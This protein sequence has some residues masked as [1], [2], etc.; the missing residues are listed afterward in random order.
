MKKLLLIL[1]LALSTTAFSQVP[2]Y[3]PTS[4]L[5]AWWPFNG[6]AI[7]ESVNTNDGTVNGATLTTDRF[8]NS[9][10]AYYFNVSHW[11]FGSGGDD[12][13]I[14]YN[15]TFNFSDF[16]VSS[17]VKRVSGGSTIDS[18][19]QWL[20]IIRRSQYGYSTPNGETWGLDIGNGASVNGPLL[21][22]GVVEQSPSPAPG[23]QCLPS[24]TVPLNQ[25]S[26]IT[27]TYSLKTI[28]LY[29]DGL[30]VCSTTN[31]GITINTVGNS[32]ISIGL[33]DQANGH[34]GPFDG[35]ID[36][37]GIWNRALTQI[38]ITA[39]FNSSNVGINE[40]SQSNLF[41]VYPNPTNSALTINSIANY[42]SI[43][44]VN[45]LGQ[46]VFTK[47]KSASLNVSSLPS[48]IYFIQLVDNKGSVIGKEKFV[49]E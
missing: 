45:M 8:G 26:F 17:W 35:K 27:M 1:S 42:T 5:V 25:W 11:S 31:T 40:V 38:E 33:S 23:F 10:S 46:V 34:W 9:N 20:S 43:Q 2:S 32:G 16:T 22:G 15:P 49:K 3:V 44:I 21:Y 13:Y 7:D 47:E 36:D 6:N 29:I 19:N 41:T 4:G 14:P 30:L 39:L 12:I 18:P 24:Q 48:G 28:S 37:I